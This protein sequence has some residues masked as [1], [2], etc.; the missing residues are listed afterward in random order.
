MRAYGAEKSLLTALVRD[1]D[2]GALA[3]T[4][5]ACPDWSVRD[6]LGH[7]V[8]S[9]QAQAEDTAPPE[10]ETDF[11]KILIGWNEAA[12]TLARNEWA[13][14]MVSCREGA[15]VAELLEEWDRWEKAAVS[16]VNRGGLSAMR[17]PWLVSDLVTH[18]QDIRGA[19]GRP[20]EPGRE[21]GQLALKTL[22]FQFDI[23]V[24]ATELP[25]LRVE[26]ADG[27]VLSGKSG[28]GATLAGTR[29]ELL[30]AFAGRRSLDQIRPM[31]SGEGAEDYL[32]LVPL[33][34][35]P[36]QPLVD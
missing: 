31:L 6:L 36:A 35:P 12:R 3:K 4:V 15:T 17:L 9:C 27:K 24:T 8:G 18:A 20:G 26:D 25:V 10:T 5:P 22:L 2:E 29:H 21:A 7:L 32:A 1:L 13:G 33:Y 30:R 23:R 34:D 14:E 11:M 28:T 16:T 19:V